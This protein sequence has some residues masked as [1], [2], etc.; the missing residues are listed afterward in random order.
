MIA[1]LSGEVFKVNTDSIYLDYAGMGFQVYMSTRDLSELAD[2]IKEYGVIEPIVVKESGA[3]YEIITG[4]RRWN[5]TFWI[6]FRSRL[7]AF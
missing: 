1:F 3:F 5:D 6:P 4:E 7:R 2:N